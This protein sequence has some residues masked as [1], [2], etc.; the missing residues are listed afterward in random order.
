MKPARPERA[1]VEQQPEQEQADGGA[2]VRA[3]DHRPP[4]D[5][6]EEP[7][8]QQR[9]REVGDPERDQIGQ[10]HRRAQPE[11]QPPAEVDREDALVEEH[12]DSAAPADP[13]SQ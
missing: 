7:A 13:P 11:G 2:Q 3:S 12:K 5:R 6:V 9:A 4:S 1:V 10:T 8:E